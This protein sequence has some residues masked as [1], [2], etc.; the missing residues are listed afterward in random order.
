[1]RPPRKR[2]SRSANGVGLSRFPGSGDGRLWLS[3]A[4]A[5]SDDA[6]RHLRDLLRR[7]RGEQMAPRRPAAGAE[8]DYPVGSGD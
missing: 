7:A 3:Q 8:V 1:M 5:W 4:Q 6:C 2:R